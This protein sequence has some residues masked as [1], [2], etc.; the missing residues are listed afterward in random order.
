MYCNNGFASLHLICTM[1]FSNRHS[2][3]EKGAPFPLFFLQFKTLWFF[4]FPASLEG[5]HTVQKLFSL[6]D[7]GNK[8]T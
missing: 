5:T 6:T 2:I 3:S 8:S 7:I 1:F 4:M